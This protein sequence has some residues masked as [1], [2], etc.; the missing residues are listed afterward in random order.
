[1]KSRILL[2]ALIGLSALAFVIFW[3]SYSTNDQENTKVFDATVNR[4]CAPW[5][6]SAFTVSIPY[7]PISTIEVSIWQSPD[8]E[9]PVTFSFPDETGRI[10]SATHRPQF[11][12]SEQLTGKVFFWHVEQGIPIEGEFNLFTEAGRQLKGKFKAN[13]GDFIAM[14]G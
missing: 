10:G 9:R 14:C 6:G 4:G 11:G 3:F 7:D 2:Y 5:D 12:S 13:W 8:M 1:M